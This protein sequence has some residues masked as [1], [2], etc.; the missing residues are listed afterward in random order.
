MVCLELQRE[1]WGSSAGTMEGQG[2]SHVASGKSILHSSCEGKHGSA[3]ESRQENQASILMEGGISRCFL[4]C[5]R[6][7]G[8]PPVAT[9]T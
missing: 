8:F 2:T 5:D 9:G 4:S 6:K 7:C 3:L 1:A